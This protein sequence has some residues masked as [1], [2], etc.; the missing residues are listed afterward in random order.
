MLGD[1]F[2]AE[3]RYR[4]VEHFL[5]DAGFDQP[6]GFLLR[7]HPVRPELEDPRDDTSFL[8]TSAIEKVEQAQGRL[9]SGD[10]LYGI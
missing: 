9:A 7:F 1:D 6:D 4:S 10:F 3:L 5:G 2:Q 8:A